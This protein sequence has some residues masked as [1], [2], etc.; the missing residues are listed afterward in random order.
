MELVHTSAT[1]TA[2]AVASESAGQAASATTSGTAADTHTG[3]SVKGSL[4][5]AFACVM[6]GVLVIGAISLVHMRR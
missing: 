2:I 1:G 6:A 3:L 5:V 4:A